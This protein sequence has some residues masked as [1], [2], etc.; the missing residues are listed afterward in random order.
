MGPK[1][2]SWSR[3]DAQDQ[4]PALP[5]MRGGDRSAA[6]SQTTNVIGDVYERG[7][8]GNVVFQADELKAEPESVFLLH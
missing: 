2:V 6:A 4:T 3:D 5:E 7:S 1:Q 8:P